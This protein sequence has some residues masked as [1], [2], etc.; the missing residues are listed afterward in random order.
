MGLSEAMAGQTEWG[1]GPRE[2]DPEKLREH[3]VN[4]KEFERCENCRFRS[5]TGCYES[6]H[7]NA[8]TNGPIP[9]E[10]QDLVEY[11]QF[12]M[13]RPYWPRVDSWDTCG[14]FKPDFAR[15]EVLARLVELKLPIRRYA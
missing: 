5:G 14:E 6:C 4:A 7:R 10:G 8:P 12:K 1:F 13:T 11:G 9:T 2:F 3:A 15:P